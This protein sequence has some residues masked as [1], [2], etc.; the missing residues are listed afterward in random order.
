MSITP[1]LPQGMTRAQFGKF[2]WGR[3]TEDAERR[4]DTI[5]REELARVGVDCEVATFWRDWYA[6]EVTRRR[7]LPTSAVRVQSMEKC[8]QLLEC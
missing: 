2:L 5:T 3:G 1:P 8:L 6:A 4:M 7:G